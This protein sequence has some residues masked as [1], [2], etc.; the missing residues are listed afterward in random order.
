MNDS[1]L[2]QRLYKRQYYLEQKANP[3]RPKRPYKRSKQKDID[4]VKERLIETDDRAAGIVRH[5]FKPKPRKKTKEEKEID[6][7][8]ERLKEVDDRNF[9][10]EELELLN[11]ITDEL[12]DFD[13]AM[14][15]ANSDEESLID[16]L[17]DDVEY[18]DDLDIF[19]MPKNYVYLPEKR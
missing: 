6:K 15:Y 2:K 7:V 5:D 18:F 14:R 11:S 17:L 19:E 8:K 3:D 9:D 13:S 10:K 12:P 4:K 1:K 16:T